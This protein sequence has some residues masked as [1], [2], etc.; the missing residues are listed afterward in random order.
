MAAVVGMCFGAHLLP[1]QYEVDHGGDKN[2]LHYSHSIFTGIFFISSISLLSYI[3]IKNFKGQELQ[4]E[5]SLLRPGFFS[6][7]IWSL[8]SIFR[9]IANEKLGISIDFPIIASGQS[10]TAALIGLLL[11]KEIKG[12]RNN[13]LLSVALFTTVVAV[14]CIAYSGR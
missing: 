9:L 3:L 8:A 12:A 13:A 7:V 2:A 14:T 1:M 5:L 10:L 11:F 6:G 4:T